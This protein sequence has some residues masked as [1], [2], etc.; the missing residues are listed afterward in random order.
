MSDSNLYSDFNPVSAKQ[1]KQK[2]QMDLK[3]A[4]YN[5][6]LMTST[7][8]G[9]V[10]KPFYH[11]ETYKKLDIPGAKTETKICQTVFIADEKKAN[12]IAK[13]AF[14]KGANIV[15][16]IADKAFDYK[17]LFN[18]LEAQE[19]R[20]VFHFLNEE[21]ITEIINFT[22][23]FKLVLQIDSIDQFVRD[24]NWFDNQ[25]S[26]FKI[27]KTIQLK[28]KNRAITSLNTQIYQNS[29]ANNVQQV[30]YALAHVNE[31]FNAGL[32]ADKSELQVTFSVG[33]HYFF[34]ISKIRAF[35]YLFKKLAQEYKL[36]VTPIICAEPTFR[37][38]TIYDYNVNL[39]RT[40]TEC[41]SAIIGG[42]DIVNNNP[43]DSIYHR[44]NEFGTRISRNQLL[45]LKE[46]SYFTNKANITKGSYYIEQLT[47][48]IADKALKLFK[49][50]EKSAGFIEQ[51]KKGTI[52]R[53][54]EES[55]AKEQAQFN[56][57]SLVLLGTNKYP[58]ENDAMKNDMELYPFIKT[59]TRQTI[60]KPIIPKRLAEQME[61]ERLK[62]EKV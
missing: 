11:Q 53:K 49:D 13:E 60:I 37:N 7:N 22:T 43:Y 46:E 10:I 59:K 18:G 21:F 5:A 34:E 27:I 24:G 57:G 9:I 42:A 40:T 33:S 62:N 8:E 17:K 31:Y 1:W 16:F 54:I 36:D 56:E 6:V 23:S 45:I 51:L 30:A 44:S 50:I 19:M 35:R 58:N 15:R 52:Q 12:G 48:E 38:K 2:I 39:L 20:L 26:D 32:I 28:N 47:F 29:G 4:D 55:A 25:L 3:G 61:Q 41:M 14:S